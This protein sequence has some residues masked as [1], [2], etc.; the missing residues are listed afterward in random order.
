MPM[1][2]YVRLVN[3]VQLKI[4]AEPVGAHSEGALI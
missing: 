1:Q 2:D 3:P 4:A